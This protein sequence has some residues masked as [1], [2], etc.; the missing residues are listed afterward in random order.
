MKKY[1]PA[2]LFLTVFE[3]I[4]VTL[5]LTKENLF[6]L[7]NFSYIGLSL[8]LGMVLFA[9]KSPC[10]RRV[11]QLLAGCCML[12]YLG[13]LRRENM[14]IEGFR[15][16]LFTGVFEGAAIHYTV[17]KLAGPPALWPGLMRLRLP[18]GPG[19]PALPRPQGGAQTLGPAPPRHLRRL[20]RLRHGPL[21]PAGP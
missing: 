8:A 16:C 18:D 5:R 15:Y 4:A 17:A 10:A 12:L 9:R 11:V 6:Y 20:P 13:L 7:L 14:R 1:L 21:P 3:A 19:L 2:A